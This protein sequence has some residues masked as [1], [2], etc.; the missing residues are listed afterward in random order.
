MRNLLNFLIKYGTWFVFTFYVLISCILLVKSSD[1]HHAI[2]LTSANAIGDFIYGTASEIT[3]YFSLKDVNERLQESN[4][5]LQN[6][7]LNL[8]NE[9]TQYKI[10][11]QDT[12]FNAISSRYDYIG[13]AVI[14]NSTRHPRNYL[15]IDR[16]KADGVEVGMGVAD[17][18]GIVGIIDAT[19]DHTSRAISLLNQSQKFSSKLKGTHYVGSLTWRGE[20]P[21]IAYMEEV[22]RHAKFQIGDTI[23]TSGFST[24][25][26]E[27]IVIGTVMGK[28]KTNDDTFFVLKVRLASD[29][30]SLG[31]VRII[32]DYYKQE[33][34]S[35]QNIE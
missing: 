18:S 35:I 12:A 14:N 5:M 1:K 13:A 9:L 17:Q 25:F 16:G 34:D 32:K 19:G 28:V 20:D 8:R 27:G 26:P 10:M 33:L 11:L 30:K 24:T 31:T 6:E 4:A 29:F 7:V 23:V 15:T 22:P 2:Y 3:G 21:T